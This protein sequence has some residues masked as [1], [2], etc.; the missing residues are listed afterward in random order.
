MSHLLD[1]NNTTVRRPN[2]ARTA[3]VALASILSL[4][5]PIAVFAAT[6]TLVIRPDATIRSQYG[7]V[8]PDMPTVTGV[9]TV[10]GAAVNCLNGLPP[11]ELVLSYADGSSDG[12]KLADAQIGE[13][14]YLTGVCANIGYNLPVG[15]RV[16][17]DSRLLPDGEHSLIFGA[18]FADQTSTAITQRIRVKNTPNC[19]PA[20]RGGDNC[21]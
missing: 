13:L 17:F 18:E 16:S 12:K 20:W 9:A 11:R 4:I 5:P 6:S 19:I 15:F 21:L 2:F 8:T 14:R 1:R 10:T 7:L 3:I